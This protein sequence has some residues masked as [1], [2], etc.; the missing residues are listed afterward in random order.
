MRNFFARIA[1]AVL[2]FAAATSPRAETCVPT[3]T[4]LAKAVADGVTVDLLSPAAASAARAIFDA[5]PPLAPPLPAS[6]AYLFTFASGALLV[7]FEHAEGAICS[8]LAVHPSRAADF[9][10]AVIGEGI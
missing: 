5:S 9:L 1:L 10:R 4:V 7:G 3:A 2:L 6:P 8:H